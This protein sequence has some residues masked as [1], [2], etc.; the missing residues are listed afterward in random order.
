MNRAEATV[1]G[2][3][4]VVLR[5]AGRLDASRADELHI[6]RAA[7]LWKESELLL[8]RA[9]AAGA[10]SAPRPGLLVDLSAVEFVDSAGIGLL[11]SIV[12]R[13]RQRGSDVACFGARDVVRRAIELCRLHTVIG[14]YD[15]EASAAAMLGLG[16]P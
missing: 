7:A 3:E 12:K 8:H 11:V 2:A 14:M 5:L 4:R 9:L 10:A 1:A 16:E 13:V 6:A 15:D